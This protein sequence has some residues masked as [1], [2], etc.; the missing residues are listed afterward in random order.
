MIYISSDWHLDHKRIIDLAERPFKST[1]EMNKV[2]LTNMFAKLKP[3]DDFYFLGDLSWSTPGYAL[4]FEMLP[5]NINFHII[6]GNHDRAS[7]F[8]KYKKQIA[9][10]SHMKDIKI[11]NIPVTL[12]HYPMITWNKSHYNAFQLFGH[13]HINSHGTDQ[14]NSHFAGKQLNVNCEMHNFQPWS[15]TEIIDYMKTR[16]DNWD[17]IPKNKRGTK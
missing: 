8:N 11:Q 1:D 6:L 12:C 16:P 5:K 3:N 10:V 17:Y 4:L 9:S 14:L 7:S 15:E 13:H 2:I